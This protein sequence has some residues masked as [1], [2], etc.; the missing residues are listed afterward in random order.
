MFAIFGTI[1]LVSSLIILGSTIFC[2]Q[3]YIKN[4]LQETQSD[5]LAAENL[6]KRKKNSK[7]FIHFG[8]REYRNISTQTYIPLDIDI[9]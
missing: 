4:I 6:I 1:V 3:A 7:K 5:I 8:E 9:V 2:C